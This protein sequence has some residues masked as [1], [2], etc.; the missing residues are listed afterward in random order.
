MKKKN[1]HTPFIIIAAV[2][3]AAAAVFALVYTG[4]AA[5]LNVN[6]VGPDPAAY[7]G[8]I[9]VTGIVAGVSA[10][11]PT[12]IGMMDKKELQCTTPNCKKLYLPFKA[13]G[14]SP[15]PGDEV[16]VTGSMVNTGGGY[17]LMGDSVKVVKNHRMGG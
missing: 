7:T 8:T 11:D 3:A 15:V 6:D 4:G 2:A 16:R 9:T 17:L 10:Q 12:I 13:P 14:Y 1:N 5:A